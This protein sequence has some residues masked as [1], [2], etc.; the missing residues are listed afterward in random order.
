M[1]TTNL[2]IPQLNLVFF[3]VPKVAGTTLKLALAEAIGKPATKETCHNMWKTVEPGD[4][5]ANYQTIALVRDPIE[6][7]LSCHRQKVIGTGRSSLESK[8]GIK[9][10]MSLAEFASIV[11]S[12]PDTKADLHIRSQHYGMMHDGKL[13]P[14]HVFRFENLAASWDGVWA[15]IGVPAPELRW[16]NKGPSVQY[17]QA[18]LDEALPLLRERYAVDIGALGY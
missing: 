3:T 18:E 15:L 1:N 8:H 17:T 11:A 5:P 10:G 13:V 4:V 12:V 2:L 16:E 14:D 7:A 6:R 9:R